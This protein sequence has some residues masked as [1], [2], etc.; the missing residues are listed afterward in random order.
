VGVAGRGTSAGRGPG[1]TA[2]RRWHTA[3]AARNRSAAPAEA[4]EPCA[5]RAGF[6]ARR[7]LA[8]AATRRQE[9]E[10]RG[11]KERAAPVPRGTTPEDPGRGLRLGSASGAQIHENVPL[12]LSP[13]PRRTRCVI[14]G[15]VR[16]GFSGG[17]ASRFRRR[18]PA[19]RPFIG[20]RRPAF[21]PGGPSARSDTLR[22]SRIRRPCRSPTGKP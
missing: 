8:V 14:P 21:R 22:R 4:T 6:A 10:S 7:T 16:P 18:A 9:P 20:T 3:P 1:S 2:T 11:R 19:T 12:R 5:A 15:G 17:R 13:K